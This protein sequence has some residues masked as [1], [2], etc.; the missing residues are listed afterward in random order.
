MLGRTGRHG[1]RLNDP[2]NGTE[3]VLHARD[4]WKLWRRPGDLTSM[5]A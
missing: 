1:L 5:L 4:A 2:V 3:L